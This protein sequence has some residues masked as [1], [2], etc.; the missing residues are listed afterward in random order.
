MS[1]SVLAP[2]NNEIES[3]A[4]TPILKWA[5]GKRQI[6]GE[7]L[8][9]MPVKYNRYFE[10]FIG[11]GALFF[12]IQSEEAFISDIN[13]ELINVYKVVRNDV[14]ELINDLRKHENDKDYFFEIRSIDRTETYK[15]W[16]NVQK[17]SRL[18][19]LNRTCFNGL[20]RV[21]SK[22]EFNV[23]FG[24]YAN[25]RILDEANLINCS[26]VLKSAQI[27]T[28]DFSAILK[29]VKKNDFVYLDPPY[30]PLNQTSAFTAYTKEGFDVSMQ[31][32]LR[33]LCVDLD[34]KGV[35]FMLS[36]S[37]TKLIND[38]YKSFN[39]NIVHATRAINSDATKRG[40][41]EEVIIRNYK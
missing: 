32:R 11:G 13:S 23:P 28:A 2:R 19:F 17:A 40:K 35:F 4:S 22:G 1:L 16:S 34:K 8:K 6:I 3:F 31:E 39:K 14:N 38:L 9:R 37:N 7:L 5:G 20:Y 25:P 41:I 18:I 15:N 10:P 36:N 26:K 21:N 33:D 24:R 30:D 12:A 29:H 27:E